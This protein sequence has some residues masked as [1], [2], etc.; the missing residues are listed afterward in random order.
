SDRFEQKAR[1]YPHRLAVKTKSQRLTYDDLNRTANRAA[2]ALLAR[3]GKGNEPV[4][5]LFKQSALLITAILG[6]LKAGRPYVP[7]NLSLPRSKATQILENL[8]ACLVLTDNE[9]SSLAHHLTHD[10]SK[11]LNLGDV[12]GT[13]PDDNPGLAVPSDQIAYVNYTS[14]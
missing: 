10:S 11:I 7:V 3:C 4:A 12:G 8:E 14:G 6:T 9:H 5:L 1:Q 2:H 13:L